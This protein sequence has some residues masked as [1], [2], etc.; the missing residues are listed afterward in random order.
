ML[1]PMVATT[2]LF[3]EDPPARSMLA[4]RDLDWSLHK[5]RRSIPSIHFNVWMP[6]DVSFCDESTSASS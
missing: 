3:M 4:D 6:V 2:S 5:Q 1:K